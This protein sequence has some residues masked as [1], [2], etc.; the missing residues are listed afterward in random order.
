MGLTAKRIPAQRAAPLRRQYR[1]SLLDDLA[2]W[3]E[4]AHDYTFAHFP[5]PDYGEWF[6]YLNR[7]GSRVRTAKANGWKGF[8]HLPRVLLRCFGLLS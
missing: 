5:D 1:A 4:R 6:G 7:D 2:A 3:Y 8:F